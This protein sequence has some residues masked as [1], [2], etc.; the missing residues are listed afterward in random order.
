V[1]GGGSLAVAWNAY[2]PLIGTP[3]NVG[4]IIQFLNQ[5]D[6]ARYRYLT[7]GFA[8]ALSQIACYTEAPSVDGEYNSGRSLPEMTR[9]GVGQLS[10][11][12]FY[13]SEGLLA[14]SEM[15]HHA[16]RYGLRYI[17]VSDPYYDPILTFGGWRQVDSYERGKI[18]VWVNPSAP[19]AAPIPSPLRPP[20]WQG[21]MWGILPVGVSIFTI[22]LAMKEYLK[23][24]RTVVDSRATD[25]EPLENPVEAYLDAS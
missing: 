15:L 16:S 23:T 2:F 21:Y 3:L 1:V 22:A 24:A 19:Y 8:N 18:T 25:D 13:G 6:H 20:R 11:A 5:G 10:T 17:F 12:K 7:L 14:L 9:H 4:P